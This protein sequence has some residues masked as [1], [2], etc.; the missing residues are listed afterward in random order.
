MLVD[1]LADAGA[2]LFEVT[3]DDEAAADAVRASTDRLA[4][5]RDGPFFVGAGTIRTEEHL[6][7]ASRA[8]AAFGVSP[9]FNRA[10]LEAAV[11]AQ[12][13][14]IPGAATPTEVELAWQSGATFVKLFPASSLGPSFVRELRGPMPEVETIPTGGIHAGNAR[15]FLDAGAV[16]VGIGSA[17][18]HANADERRALVAGVREAVPRE[19]SSGPDL[20][21]GGPGPEA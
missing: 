9:T 6:R 21:T 14:F 1:E 19:E 3:F 7:V 12:L 4:H 20:R 5:R 10:V 13:P 16:A 2:R 18:L 8:E 11:N 15:Q 17:L